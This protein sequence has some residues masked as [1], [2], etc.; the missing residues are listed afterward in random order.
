MAHRDFIF[1]NVSLYKI[2]V[3][4][5]V[6]KSLKFSA[7][8]I[9]FSDSVLFSPICETIWLAKI[10]FGKCLSSEWL[11]FGSRYDFLEM[12]ICVTN[13]FIMTSSVLCRENQNVH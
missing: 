1:N 4:R 3:C 13:I 9:I 2:L 11:K 5:F 12:L 7:I 10:F 8:F 6:E